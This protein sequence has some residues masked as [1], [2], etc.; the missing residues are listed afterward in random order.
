LYANKIT[1]AEEA[2][3][4]MS[5]Q[6]EF[7]KELKSDQ[8]QQGD[9][10]FDKQLDGAEGTFE[11]KDTE[12]SSETALEYR[13]RRERRLEEKYR[14]EREA[15]IAL[16]A[17]LQGM[18]EARKFSEEV[19]QD[20]SIK[21]VRAIY[22]DDTPEKKQASDLL[23]STL[24]KLQ[25]SAVERA[26]EKLREERG[27]EDVAVQ[28][29]EENLDSMMEGIEDEYG[30]DF[31]DPN[32]RNGFLTL[33][34]KA[35][36]KDRDGYIVEYADPTTVWELYESRMTRSSSRA[37]ELAS[38]GMTRSGASKESKIQ[39]DSTLR[40]LRENGII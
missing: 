26:L 9:D 5:E 15:N 14:A 8:A 24:R 33:L 27:S 12:D 19:G 13:R 16:N 21:A 7:L 32:V 20:D 34:E 31:S 22:G 2:H 29:E 23:E 10:I 28:K 35:S 38:R 30:A 11:K 25:D 17:R 3:T 6:S 18:S 37:K 4:S 39:D 36:P 1:D 40:F